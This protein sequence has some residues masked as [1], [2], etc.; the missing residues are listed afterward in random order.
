MHPS[1][2]ILVACTRAAPVYHDAVHGPALRGAV[3]MMVDAPTPDPAVASVAARAARAM[4]DGRAHV[5][6]SFLSGE[7]LDAAR[8]DM[9]S[10]LAHMVPGD[11]EDFQSIQTDL[12]N[13]DFRRQLPAPLPFAGLLS[14]LDAL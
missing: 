13:P 2:A 1:V 4:S 9:G 8:A 14:E 5:E 3:R 12:L 10:V 11:G 6:P 7:R